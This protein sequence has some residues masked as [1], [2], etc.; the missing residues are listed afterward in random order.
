MSD[1]ILLFFVIA[2]IVL[3]LVL[4]L[5]NPRSAT[6]K[7]FSGLI[8]ILT[9][10]LAVNTEMVLFQD[11]EV[12]LI[13]SRLIISLGAVING[14]VFLFL[15]TFPQDRIKLKSSII[16][17]VSWSTAGLF[18][19]GFTPLI[20]SGIDINNNVV[21]PKPGILMPI[22]LVHTI[23]LI[24]GG[25]VSIFL[26]YK[27]SV[28][29]EKNRIQYVLLSFFILFSLVIILNF[30]LPVFLKIGFFVPFLPIYI[31]IF[32]LIVGYAI[33]RQRLMDIR[34]L[35]GRAVVYVLLLLMVAAFFSATLL[36]AGYRFIGIS[37]SSTQSIFFI[38]ILVITAISFHPVQLIVEKFTE[39]LL[40]KNRYDIND[41]LTHLNKIMASTLQL[42]EL[43]H[44]ILRE[45][46]TQLK[47]H[48]LTFI[49]F[50]KDDVSDVITEG[51]QSPPTYKAEDIRQITQSQEVLVFED[52]EEGP[53][54]NTMRSLDF[55]V[56]A[57]L[58]TE[59]KQI[60]L[61]AFGQKS[62]GEIYSSQDI[63]LVTILSPEA[64]IAIQNALSYEQV[65]RFNVTLQ[66]EIEK[67]TTDLKSAN[68]QLEV[69]DKLKDEFVSVAS[70]ELRTP[71]TAIKSYAWM[72][73][74]N[75]AGEISPKAHIYLDRV[76]TSTER[77]IHLVNEM[78]DVSRIESGRVTLHKTSINP[79]DLCDDMQTEFAAKVADAQ[80][81]FTIHKPDMLPSIEIDQEKIT[82]VL[83]NLI[84]NSI[85]YSQ[86]GATITLTVTQEGNL[87]RF[88]IADTGRGIASDDMPKLFKKF[89]RLENSLVTVTAESSG[90]GLFISKQYVELHGGTV[91]VQ[92]ELGK[93]STFSFTLPI[94]SDTNPLQSS[95][96]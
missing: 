53:I 90:L 3:S 70:H 85:K 67:A 32:N 58:R 13:L 15:T 54:K 56:V 92:S 66:E 34:V 46:K 68:T 81:T 62:S 91:D 96:S 17:M 11:A 21:T 42:D 16:H 82:Q 29:L 47:I 31:L 5:N 28:G 74:N 57:Q 69:L 87:V 52:L 36:F 51:F 60:G 80:V 94:I 93:G 43:A 24:F 37:F 49:F 55:S 25:I 2:N 88:S 8:I 84:G 76:Y 65:R 40:F 14:F 23:V 83:E 38:I 4:F 95:V 44:K 59:G 63:Q 35:V 48:T 18:I 19:A 61:L 26:R 9:I 89:G 41:V 6:N 30:I 73:L 78:L 27:K 33:V 1:V 22:F 79:L 7:L 77:L 75:K 10:Y 39:K 86:K 64:A 12:K 72:V 71:M 45:L 20:F 50:E